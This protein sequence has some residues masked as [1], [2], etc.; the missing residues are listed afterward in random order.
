MDAISPDDL[1]VYESWEEEKGKQTRHID[2]LV[3]KKI[4]KDDDGNAYRIVKMEYD[5]LIKH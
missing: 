4:V 1:S 3:L 2:P 5:F